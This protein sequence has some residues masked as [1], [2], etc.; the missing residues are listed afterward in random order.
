MVTGGSYPDVGVSS[1]SDEEDCH[2][3]VDGTGYR[4]FRSECTDCRCLPS[5]APGG[6]GA[7]PTGKSDR[8]KAVAP[9]GRDTKAA[10]GGS[11]T[12]GGETCSLG[13]TAGAGANHGGPEK[14]GDL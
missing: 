13:S 10:G 7:A 3:S 8:D 5:G 14:E 12:R 6:R 1:D 11:R 4:R 2:P 9:R